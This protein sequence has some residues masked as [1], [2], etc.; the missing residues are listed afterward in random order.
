MLVK[1]DFEKAFD[2]VNWLCLRSMLL[3][4]GFREKWISWIEECV[5]SARLS[6]I[7]NG[8]LTQEFSPQRGLRQGDPLSHFLFNLA[9]EGLSIL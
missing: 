6:V 1:L 9:A 3:N 4:F 7:V 5:S 8:S 2:S